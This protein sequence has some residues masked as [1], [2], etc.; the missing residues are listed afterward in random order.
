MRQEG[1]CRS[2]NVDTN[3]YTGYVATDQAVHELHRPMITKYIVT[4]HQLALGRSTPFD[5][6]QQ[7]CKVR[8]TSNIECIIMLWTTSVIDR[9]R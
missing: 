8:C 5:L 2:V 9:S 4:I 1:T 3:T 7:R 6:V